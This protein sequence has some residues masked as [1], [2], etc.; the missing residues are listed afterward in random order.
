MLLRIYFVFSVLLFVAVQLYNLADTK[1]N[2]PSD[3]ARKSKGSINFE[4]YIAT[5]AHG[6]IV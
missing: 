6:K 4:D 5:A 2:I 1:E 3:L